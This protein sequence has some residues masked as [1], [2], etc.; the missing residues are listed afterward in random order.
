MNLAGSQIMLSH[1]QQVVPHAESSVKVVNNPI[2]NSGLHKNKKKEE[3]SDIKKRPSTTT[4][5]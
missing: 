1:L 2:A 3:T 5:Q 4:S